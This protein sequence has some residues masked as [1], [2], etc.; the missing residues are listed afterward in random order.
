MQSRSQNISKCTGNVSKNTRILLVKPTK[1]GIGGGHGGGLPPLREPLPDCIR[2]DMPLSLKVW[3][4]WALS[5]ETM[6]LMRPWETRREINGYP[7]TTFD[8]LRTFLGELDSRYQSS[9]HV[10]T[11]YMEYMF[12]FRWCPPEE[13][14][15]K[16]SSTRRGEFDSSTPEAIGVLLGYIFLAWRFRV[17]LVTLE[18]L[19]DKKMRVGSLHS[20][21]EYDG[22][23]PP[24]A[25]Y[26][27]DLVLPRSRN[28]EKK[29]VQV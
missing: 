14:D 9:I 26:C 10:A 2:E 22:R 7:F 24:D 16:R 27:M 4:C 28:L 8:F 18:T 12:F 15:N 19:P 3:D 23:L 25:G 20:P 21:W 17:V 29:H 11:V 6:R 5:F 1:S 13:L